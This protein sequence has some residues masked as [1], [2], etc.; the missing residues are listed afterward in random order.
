MSTD[1]LSVQNWTE[2]VSFFA[3]G[4]ISDE[5]LYVISFIRIDIADER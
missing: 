1:T 5:Y 4:C 2:S 3:V